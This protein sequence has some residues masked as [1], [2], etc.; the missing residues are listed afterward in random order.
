MVGI[1]PVFLRGPIT[2]PRGRKSTVDTAGQTKSVYGTQ[3]I[4]ESTH[5]PESRRYAALLLK[6]NE[7]CKPCPCP[8][9]GVWSDAE[10]RNLS[11][12]SRPQP[13]RQH[14]E[15]ATEDCTARPRMLPA[16]AMLHGILR[17]LSRGPVR[18]WAYAVHDENVSP[19]G[20]EQARLKP[21]KIL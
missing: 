19:R 16:S 10:K 12:I 1:H 13:G 11:S 15:I 4:N 5:S 3:Y 20:L 17:P 2:L 6:K 7:P 8:P 21:S 18:V 9:W 14:A